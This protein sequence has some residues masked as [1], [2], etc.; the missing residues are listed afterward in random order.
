[1][2]ETMNKGLKVLLAVSLSGML[3]LTG[4][5][6]D[7]TADNT[8]AGSENATGQ[9]QEQVVEIVA[10]VNGFDITKADYD[11]N[12]SLIEKNYN[13]K[14]GD[15]I[16]TQEINGKTMR[17]VIRTQLL[18][19]MISEQLIVQN[20]EKTGFKA[21]EEK[22]TT[23]YDELMAYFEKNEDVKKFYDEIGVDESFIKNQIRKQLIVDEFYKNIQSEVEKDITKL[24]ELYST[25]IIKV[26]ASHILVE[27]LELA[28]DLMSQLSEGGDFAELAKEHSKD[29]GSGSNGGALGFFTRGRM[30]PEFE[31]AAFSTEKGK[32]SSI[33]Q[34]DYGFH[35]ILVNDRLTINQLVELEGETAE[36]EQLKKS[37]VNSLVSPMVTKAQEDLKNAAEIETVEE[38]IQ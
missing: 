33:V 36:V 37:I 22:I 26:D 13:D 24:E 30:V 1:M 23:S 27:N 4:C 6:G 10:K 35:I 14:Y 19:D 38:N 21:E 9:T 16:W 18:E 29:P 7:K 17:E 11:K 2:G 20:V 8:E 5:S 28:N 25:E 3:M 34:T 15:T 31:A 12:F 32:I